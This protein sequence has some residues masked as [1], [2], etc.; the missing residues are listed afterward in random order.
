MAKLW[1]EKKG[2]AFNLVG[3][4]GEWINVGFPS[5]F[6]ARQWAREWDHEIVEAPRGKK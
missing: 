6:V 1:I 2:N 4:A 5:E 3:K